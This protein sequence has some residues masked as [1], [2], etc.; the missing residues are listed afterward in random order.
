[1]RHAFVLLALIA[2]CKAGENNNKKP[3]EPA[4]TPSVQPTPAEA[5][6][7]MTPPNPNGPPTDLVKGANQLAV[8]LWSKLPTTGNLAVSPASIAVPLTV[9]WGGAKGTTAAQLQKLLGFSGPA[10]VVL[11]R[12]GNLARSL[13]DPK[14]PVTLK[15]ANRLYAEKTY[16]VDTTYFTV[17]R[18][19]MDVWIEPVD[20]VSSTEEVRAK[21]NTWVA[22]QTEQR[23]KNLLPPRSVGPA[24][25]LVIVNAIYFLGDWAKPFE[26]AQT[27][28]REFWVNGTTSAQLPTMQKLD[29][30][31][32]AR[33]EGASLVELPYKGNS[34]AMY[35]LVPDARD[36]LTAL[37]KQVGATLKALQPKLAAQQVLLLLPKF[38]IDPPEPLRLDTALQALGVTD[39]FDPTAADFT[40]MAN[41]KDPR[42]RLFVSGVIHK[43]F[44]K[45]DEKGTEAAA[46]TAIAAPGG[47]PPPKPVELRVDHPFLFVIVDKPT[48]LILFMGRVVDPS[49]GAR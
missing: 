11:S 1:M 23:I 16:E 37:E 42:D 22:E 34:L 44:V 38:T 19:A 47:G 2:A 24:T 21:I 40:G 18:H 33:G 29:Q 17:A 31:S 48:G 27:K 9:A 6:P 49:D 36:G 12:W 14:R 7:P 30:L 5:P 28:P 8:E 13:V 32:I 45:V 10:D 15:I 25:K 4:P 43:A 3:A 20:F 39:A 35:V 46:A 41:P 26:V